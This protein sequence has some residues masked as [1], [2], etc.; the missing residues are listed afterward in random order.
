M[1]DAEERD[2][3]V[4][5][6]VLISGGRAEFAED[7]AALRVD[8]GAVVFARCARRS[9]VAKLR[10]GHGRGIGLRAAGEGIGG[11]E[12]LDGVGAEH[13]MVG[14][15]AVDL[16]VPMSAAGEIPA[17]IGAEIVE[18]VDL[19]EARRGE[20][21]LAGNARFAGVIAK[22]DAEL[23]GFAE[24]VAEVSGDGAIAEGVVG[25]LSFGSEV[26]GRAGIVERT[27]QAA[28]LGAAACGGKTAAFG[29]HIER[30]NACFAAMRK[31]LNDAGGRVG[32]VKGAFG[33]AHDFDFVDV[34]ER[35]VRE[36]K[37]AARKIY[38]GAV[39]DHF[40]LVGVAAVQENSGEPSFGAGAVDSDSR[41]VQ[42]NIGQ[43]HGLAIINFITRDDDDGSGGFLRQ[44]RF[45]LRGDYHARREALQFQVQIE[46]AGLARRKIQ[47]EFAG[48]EGFAGELNAV[49][50]RRESERIG[51][52]VCG[53]RGQESG[54]GRVL[55]LRGDA[56]AGNSRAAGV[57][58]G[59]GKVSSRRIGLGLQ[60]KT[61]CEYEKNKKSGTAKRWAHFYPPLP[62]AW[63]L[64]GWP[65]DKRNARA[66]NFAGLLAWRGV[67]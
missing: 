3:G 19:V 55:Q 33:A 35:E 18:V 31:H 9:E 38:G 22:R 62:H 44:C 25:A 10:G 34:V 49:A 41:G 52:V 36:V 63:E 21:S 26:R 46:L 2:V 24:G 67:R 37:R 66:A 12:T 53:G 27:E 1:S 57:Q 51:A 23:I 11:K 20:Q 28:E 58:Q 6:F 39:D 61:E 29:E 8:A 43:G 48:R 65:G 15:G 16:M 13:V 50:A 54:V 40:G 7:V 60:G 32:A 59:A 56:N 64:E 14:L 45:R 30:R 47:N 42:Q 5:D 17:G 4:L